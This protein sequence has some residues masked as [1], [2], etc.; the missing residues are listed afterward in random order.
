M[1][2]GQPNYWQEDPGPQNTTT[3]QPAV[4]DSKIRKLILQTI[5][6]VEERAKVVWAYISALLFAILKSRQLQ[7]KSEV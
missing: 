4:A 1:A 7:L 5:F 2:R 3:A 6:Q